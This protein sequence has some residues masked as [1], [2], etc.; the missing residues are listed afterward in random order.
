MPAGRGQVEE[1]TS[2]RRRR[3]P[4]P[5]AVRLG[6]VRLQAGPIVVAR[7]SNGVG[8]GTDV[9]LEQA[10]DGAVSA[11]SPEERQIVAPP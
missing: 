11:R 2:V 4:P 10:S 7:L 6:S 8:P 5:Q 1:E 3:D 9:W